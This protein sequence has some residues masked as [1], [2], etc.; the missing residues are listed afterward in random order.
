MTTTL[1]ERVTNWNYPGEGEIWE[2]NKSGIRVEI[3]I[4][5]LGEVI[6]RY[7][8]DGDPVPDGRDAMSS[9]I[10]RFS[11]VSKPD[12]RLIEQQP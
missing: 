5:G 11:L 6:Y 1:G 2:N 9:F 7:I 10:G 8:T 3:I 4:A 12:P